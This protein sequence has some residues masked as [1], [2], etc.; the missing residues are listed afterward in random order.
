M[1]LR[2]SWVFLL[3]GVI[4]VGLIQVQDVRATA[5]RFEYYFDHPRHTES[6]DSTLK[7]TRNKLKKM[8]SIDLEFTADGY[9]V[10]SLSR[11]DSLVGGKFPDWGAAAAIPHWKRIVI[12]SPDT[13]PLSRPLAELLAHEYSH[14]ALAYRTRSRPVPRWL[15]E[16]MAMM[17]SMQWSWGDN[18]TMNLAAVLGNFIPLAEIDRVNRFGQQRAHLAYAQSYMA[19]QYIYEQYG[20]EGMT[21]LLDSIAVSVPLDSGLMA[22]TGSNY[23][24]FEAELSVYLQEKYNFVSLVSDTMYFWLILAIILI[25]GGILSYRRRRLY[26]Q[27]WEEE[28]KYASTD[29]DYGDPDAPEQ[30]DDDEPWRQ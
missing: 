16:G 6:A 12:K 15:D 5:P 23:S 4:L 13:F 7:A 19:V 22:A 11:F 26:L 24:D 3:V 10:G 29:F 30:T 2:H 8:L 28:E 18:L 1:V 27:K 9:L 20:V 21:I 17:V 14:L 25:A